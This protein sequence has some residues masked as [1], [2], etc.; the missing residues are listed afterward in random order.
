LDRRAIGDKTLTA[1]AFIQEVRLD[2]RFA[3][4][5]ARAVV[6]NLAKILE[7]ADFRGDND[8]NERSLADAFQFILGQQ[9]LTIEKRMQHIV[10]LCDLIERVGKI[11]NMDLNAFIGLQ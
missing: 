5:R 1:A 8:A 2:P 3:G 6:N 7:D 10:R 4:Q 11:E 9:S